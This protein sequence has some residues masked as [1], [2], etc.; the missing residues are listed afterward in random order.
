MATLQGVLEGPSFE[1][2]LVRSDDC[3]TATSEIS[4]IGHQE[5]P[6][7]LAVISQHEIAHVEHTITKFLY[8]A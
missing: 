1:R 8:K 4:V 6:L 2:S 7:F 5:E 3:D